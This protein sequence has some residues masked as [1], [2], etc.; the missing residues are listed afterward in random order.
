[1]NKISTETVAKLKEIIVKEVKF[2]IID[3]VHGQNLDIF[4]KHIHSVQFEY[5]I[6][7]NRQTLA[8]K[9]MLKLLSEVFTAI[10][11]SYIVR[12]KINITAPT[13]NY[14]VD[15]LIHTEEL[16]PNSKSCILFLTSNP[17]SGTKMQDG[18]FFESI[19][20]NFHTFNSNRKHYGIPSKNGKARCAINIV[21]KEN[22]E[23]SS[24]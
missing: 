18:V 23:N 21:Y 15:D 24:K 14:I 6:D 16:I 7:L 12:L 19:E 2:S 1:M 8:D 13:N 11:L 22:N 9:K 17:N 20:G 4:D 3:K 10:N 5:K